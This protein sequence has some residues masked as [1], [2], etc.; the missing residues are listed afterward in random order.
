MT[1]IIHNENTKTL[2]ISVRIFTDDLEKELAKDCN[3][4]VDLSKNEL[5]SSMEIM[6]K[7]YLKKALKIKKDEKLLDI[8]FLGFEKEEESTWS[9]LEVK[10]QPDANRLEITNKILFQTQPRQSNLIRL[11]KRDFDKTRQLSYPESTI[12]F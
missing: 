2:E 1:E 10:L 7:N 4:K 12:R 5:H 8:Q 3:C 11:K 9:F 6:I